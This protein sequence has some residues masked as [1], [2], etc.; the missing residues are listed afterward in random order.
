MVIL[1]L[2]LSWNH[3]DDCSYHSSFS[4]LSVVS[5]SVGDGDY[6]C[7]CAMMFDVTTDDI[8][9]LKS[10]QALLLLLLLATLKE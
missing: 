4:Y 10:I 6:E 2:D 5:P 8:V 1:S 7:N 9:G 3:G